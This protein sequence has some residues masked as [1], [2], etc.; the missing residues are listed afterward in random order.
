MQPPKLLTTRDFTGGLNLNRN[1]MQLEANES[2]DMLNM[3]IDRHGGI[4]LRRG[5][6]VAG[7]T[8]MTDR[9]VSFG[10]LDTAAGVHK[11][12]AF[13]GTKMWASS[14]LPTWTSAANRTGIN[15]TVVWNDKLYA[16]NGV[17]DA[18]TY[19]GTTV[20]NLSDAFQNNRSVPTNGNM[21]KAELI[22]VYRG[23]I[24]V[25]NTTESSNRYPSRIRWS[26]VN[27]GEDW[28]DSDFID[29]DLG[30]DGDE[31]KALVPFDDR[32]LVF[33]E[34]SIHVLYGDPPNGFSVQLLSSTLGTLSQESV[35]VT[36]RGVFF[37]DWPSGV[38]VWTGRSF[39]WVFERLEP[40]IS[41]S[42]M[43]MARPDR[44]CL[45][46]HDH[47]VWLSVNEAPGLG[48]G[49]THCYVASIDTKGTPWVRYD[50]P[51]GCFWSWDPPGLTDV[52]TF[53]AA[54][55]SASVPIMLEQP[56]YFDDHGSTY[57]GQVHIES[58][59]QTPWFDMGQHV[60]KKRWRRPELVLKSGQ[61]A[62]IYVDVMKDY[63]PSH[64][65]S[66]QLLTTVPVAADALWDVA[67]W[68]EDAWNASGGES[69]MV[70]RGGNMG[71]ARSVSLA[72][73]GPLTNHDWGV[74][75]L[76]LKTQPKPV[77]S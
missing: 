63:D 28:V 74:N 31:I 52:P 61:A 10:Q 59:Y 46:F 75:A 14:A 45:G 11:V 47:R 54:W 35:V 68:D 51:A 67:K 18:I 69:W 70:A 21:P 9:I 38:H 8:A 72:L 26:H 36:D 71:T 17:N 57:G 7:S 12:V 62:T 25:A 32:L 56:F 27:H 58:H 41:D 1:L 65:V 22:A 64:I 48:T 34:R 50:I 44:V 20:A 29:I 43:S 42:I 77:R 2:P 19:D 55:H 16:V 3:D 39:D 13:D 23:C 30:H 6:K 15:R 33:K 37:F 4:R 60:V 24:V 76:T 40:L 49:N 5:Y 73:R 53:L 66:T